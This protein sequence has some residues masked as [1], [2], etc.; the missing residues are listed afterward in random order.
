VEKEMTMIEEKYRHVA[1]FSQNGVEAIRRTGVRV[2]EMRERYVKMMMPIGGNTNHIGMM[3]AGSLFALGEVIG[4]A[5]FGAAFDYMKFFPI[6]KELSIR[7]RRPALTDVT[8]VAE[9]S[10][11]AVRDIVKELEAKDKAEIVLDLEL[12]DAGG[13]V[14]A[15]VHGV[16]Q[17]RKIPE[18]FAVPWA[19]A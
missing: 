7:Y 9:V 14:V 5:L 10:A 6:A 8:L 1:D 13:E 2:L 16:W 19:K 17:A 11:E 12:K 15:L 3:Y 18:G 4:G